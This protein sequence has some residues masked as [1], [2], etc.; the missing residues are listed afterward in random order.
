L[1]HELR[2]RQVSA[3]RTQYKVSSNERHASLFANGRMQPKLFKTCFSVAEMQPYLR[4]SEHRR[5]VQGKNI[6][7]STPKEEFFKNIH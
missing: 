6:N 2:P 7:F 4:N 3:N 1:F 5:R